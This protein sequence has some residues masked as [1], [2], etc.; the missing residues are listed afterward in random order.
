MRRKW[1]TAALCSAPMAR[2]TDET[3]L[4][5]K[6]LNRNDDVQAALCAEIHIF[7]C[8]VHPDSLMSALAKLMA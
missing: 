3:A 6:A 5:H 1:R 7:R 4:D 8:I 2:G